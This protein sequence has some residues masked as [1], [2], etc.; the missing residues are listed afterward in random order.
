MINKKLSITLF[1]ASFALFSGAIVATSNVHSHADSNIKATTSG[2]Q[3]D[4][5]VLARTNSKPHYY[6]DDGFKAGL[7]TVRAAQ[8]TFPALTNH[9]KYED[10]Y[11][12]GKFIG[13]AINTFNYEDYT[14]GF[15]QKNVSDNS[16]V[17]HLAVQAYSDGLNSVNDKPQFTDFP[18]TQDALVYQTAFKAGVARNKLIAQS[19]TKAY[20]QGFKA[21]Y[22]IHLNKDVKYP[23][24]LAKTSYA[25]YKTGFTVGNGLRVGLEAAKHHVPVTPSQVNDINF[26]F[27]YKGY[28]AGRKDVTKHPDKHISLKN[29]D[30]RYKYAY[31]KAIDDY[32]VK[33]AKKAIAHA[34]SDVKHHKVMSIKYAEKHYSIG[35][36]QVYYV[37][38][39]MYG[40]KHAPKYVTVKRNIRAHKTTK[41]TTKNVTK[42]FK[43]HT[44]IKV[45][46]VGFDNHGHARYKIG[47]L[48]YIT[49]SAHF[50]R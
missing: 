17:Y 44:H 24:K 23:K 50:V 22:K 35:Y 49:M 36:R 29:K 32:A 15:K 46:G 6:F 33:T 27:G 34:K 13:V 19:H 37:N 40:K 10:G 7:S 26:Y 30:F 16:H 43:N 1:T 18:S 48:G 11:K 45:T 4:L 39:I 9:G 41:F 38:Y 5:A 31:Y 28:Q 20:K 47:K 2:D 21:G 3:S 25:S 42:H 8:T 14:V 12:L